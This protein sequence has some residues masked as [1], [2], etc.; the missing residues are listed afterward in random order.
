[1]SRNFTI[2]AVS[3][4]LLF[5]L[6]GCTVEPY[7]TAEQRVKLRRGSLYVRPSEH[8]NLCHLENSPENVKFEYQEIF[9]FVVINVGDLQM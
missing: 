3:C 2:V 7:S 1:M 6:L 5:A 8:L 4:Q 9:I